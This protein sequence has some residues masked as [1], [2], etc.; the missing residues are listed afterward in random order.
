MENGW[1]SSSSLLIDNINLWSLVYKLQEKLVE[2]S[3][4]VNDGIL[5]GGRRHSRSFYRIPV[6]V[7]V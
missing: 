2:E 7:N 5:T 6:S 1:Y 3:I 4:F